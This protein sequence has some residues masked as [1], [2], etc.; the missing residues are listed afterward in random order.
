M[1]RTEPLET[2][3]RIAA[4]DALASATDGSNGKYSDIIV[5]VLG[6]NSR[7]WTDSHRLLLWGLSS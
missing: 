2:E 4:P 6:D 5:V 1:T 7:V 3:A